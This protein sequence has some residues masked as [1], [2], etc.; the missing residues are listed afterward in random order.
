MFHFHCFLELI[1]MEKIRGMPHIPWLSLPWA[2]Y[3]LKCKYSCL[4]LLPESYHNVKSL[5]NSYNAAPKLLQIFSFLFHK[6]GS[7]CVRFYWQECL[8]Y[9][10][11]ICISKAMHLCLSLVRFCEEPYSSL[12]TSLLNKRFC[13]GIHHYFQSMYFVSQHVDV[14]KDKFYQNGQG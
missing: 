11:G 6:Q 3:Y 7:T 5:P 4:S 1:N 10:S 14:V 12:I 2:L 9:V 13:L 8:S